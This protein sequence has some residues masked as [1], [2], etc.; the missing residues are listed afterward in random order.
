MNDSAFPSALFPRH[1]VND[2]LKVIVS[3]S[4]RR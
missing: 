2:K 1:S 4:A 3:S